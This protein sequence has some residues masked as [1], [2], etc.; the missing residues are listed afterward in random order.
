MCGRRHPTCLHEER[1]RK[2]GE[3][4]TK[5]SASTHGQ[6]TQVIPKVNSLAAIREASATSSIVPVFLS[7]VK[8]PEKEILTYA[9]LDTQSDSSFVLEDLVRELKVD[10]QPQQL[11]LS[12]MTAVDTVITSQSV[13]GLKVRSF[14]NANHVCYGKHIHVTLFLLISLVYQ[15]HLQLCSGLILNI[16]QRSCH[17]FK[18]AMWDC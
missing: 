5:G 11:K 2:P 7:S 17:L 12:T 6:A 10:A 8:E 16:L 3:A 9:L 13:S 14:H 15:L 1:E 18:T 4:T